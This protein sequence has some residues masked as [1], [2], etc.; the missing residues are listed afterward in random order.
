MLLSNERML[1][2]RKVAADIDDPDARRDREARAMRDLLAEVE[3]LRIAVPF[4]ESD[5]MTLVQSIRRV[6]CPEHDDAPNGGASSERIQA[7]IEKHAPNRFPSADGELERRTR[8]AF[9]DGYHF[10]KTT[11]DARIGEAVAEWRHARSK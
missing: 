10:R 8:K 6:A 5:L 9:L 11:L 1:E 3:R 2:I 4:T 7:W